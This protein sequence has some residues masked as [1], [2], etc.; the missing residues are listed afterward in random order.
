MH[1]TRSLAPL[2]FLSVMLG[3]WAAGCSRQ[4]TEAEVVMEPSPAVATPPSALESQETPPAAPVDWEESAAGEP[5]PS[6]TAAA[7]ANKPVTVVVWISVDGL[8][9]DYVDSVDAPFLERFLAEGAYSRELAPVFPSLTFPAHVSQCTGALVRDHGIIGNAIYDIVNDHRVSYPND[10]SLILCEPIW[11]TVK[12][13]GLRSAVFDWPVSQKQIGPDA[14]DYFT[15]SYD[16]GLSD[17]H[18]L[19]QLWDAWNRDRDPQPLQLLMGYFPGVDSAGHKYGPHAR[20]TK[21]V[22]QQADALLAEFF[23]QC[24]QLIHEKHGDNV[25]WYF[26]VS[27]DHGMDDIHTLV[28]LRGLLAD[29]YTEDVRTLTS[30]S[31]GNIFLDY[32]TDPEAKRVLRSYILEKL[33]RHSFAHAYAREDLPAEWGYDSP[34]RT[35]DV[36]VSIDPGYFFSESPGAPI[37]PVDPES[38]PLG[39]HGYP[40][41]DCP[42]MHG[43]L[44]IWR[45]GEPLGGIDLGVVDSRRLHSTVAKLLEIEPAPT[46]LDDPLPG[47]RSGS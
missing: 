40:L 30:G 26:I 7:V 3:L 34:G 5:A 38:G 1:R 16:T 39:M 15:Q 24:K 19:E 45:N 25:Q 47:L 12:R 36:V 8:R 46:A 22:V 33:Q 13:Q 17:Q 21:S 18:R 23:Q 4:A 11:N 27:T 10:N 6:T 44:G 9:G 37:R 42:E 35:G 29:A 20:E 28:S 43:F 2:M 14:A 31:V 32:V 41:A